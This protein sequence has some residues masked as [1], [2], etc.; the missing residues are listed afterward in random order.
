M[1]EPTVA[2]I[3]VRIPQVTPN[4]LKSYGFGNSISPLCT[5]SELL[6]AEY[7]VQQLDVAGIDVI[8]DDLRIASNHEYQ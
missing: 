8:V 7:Q 2:E 6:L 1:V 3:K 4:N 5:A